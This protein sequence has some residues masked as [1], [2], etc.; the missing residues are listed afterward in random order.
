LAGA[1]PLT[2]TFTDLSSGQMDSYRWSYGDGITSTTT[3][4]THT[5]TYTGA[6]VYTVTLTVEG[7]G[8]TDT[9]TRASYITAYE[10]VIADF[11]ASPLTGT[12]PLTVTYVNNSTGASSYLWDFG[13]GISDTAISPTHTYTRA[14]VYTVSLTAVGPGG[15]DTLTRTHYITA[16]PSTTIFTP[17]WWNDYFFFR[18][19]ML[20]SVVEPISYTPGVTTV[21]RVTLDTAS[22]VA[23]Q[24]LRADGQDLRVLYWNESSGWSELPRAVEGINT[25]TTTLSL[26]STVRLTTSNDLPSV[27]PGGFFARWWV[28]YRNNRAKEHP[29][30]SGL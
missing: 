13:D 1:V 30:P 4:L 18:R 17:V 7:P 29:A 19:Q 22:L 27:M 6:S 21:L 10:T 23:G 28:V 20:L 25:T 9:L 12:V 24:K 3:T 14:G 5:H 8:G 16:N 11:A 15:S 2:V 26:F